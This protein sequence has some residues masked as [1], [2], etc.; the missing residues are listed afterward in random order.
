[1]ETLSRFVIRIAAL[2]IYVLNS[3]DQGPPVSSKSDTRLKPKDIPS[4]AEE[5]PVPGD[6]HVDAR[7]NMHAP[8][9][10][11][12]VDGSHISYAGSNVGSTTT[13]QHLALPKPSIVTTTPPMSHSHN[14]AGSSKRKRD[15][16][17][18]DDDSNQIK[19][20]KDDGTETQEKG[21]KEEVDSQS[22]DDWP[23]TKSIVSLLT[24]W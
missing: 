24:G 11:G 15:P 2:F 7:V 3:S 14:E 18:E 6:L 12:R 13:N 21:E 9:K 8:A 5:K 23:I 10:S 19:K 4:E 16:F 17:E 20:R 22:A 1:M